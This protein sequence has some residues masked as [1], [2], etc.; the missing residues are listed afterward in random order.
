MVCARNEASMTGMD[1]DDFPP[2]PV[3]DGATVNLDTTTLKLAIDQVEFA[4]AVD[5]TRPVLTGV[6]V[7]LEGE[8]LTL[9]SADGFRLA[10][11]KLPLGSPL[12][13]RAE[14]IIPARTLREINRLLTDEAESVEL[15]INAGHS[16]VLFRLG[17]VEMVS[18][19]I[20]GTFPNY[21]QLIPQSYTS[22]AVMEV[23]EFL[24]ETRIAAIFARDGSGIV[25]LQMNSGKVTISSRAEEVGDNR[26][27]V[28]AQVEGEESRIAFN[29]RYLQE[30]LQVLA[31]KQVALE[32][33]GPSSPGLLR[34]VG[35]EN[36][37]HVI[38]PMFVQW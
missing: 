3:V 2:I 29:S 17:N 24:R 36:Y 7:L 33:T 12:G 31:V 23:D 32:T 8:E 13:E 10:V 4:A 25:R 22:R 9:A 14:V 18:Q 6:H 5:D 34:P 27:E 11:H 20:Q 26:G 16:R 28:D 38:M 1:A 35:V 21:G 37:V 30:V 15:T 19:L